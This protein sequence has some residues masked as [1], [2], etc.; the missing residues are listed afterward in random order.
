MTTTKKKTTKKK[1]RR[2]KAAAKPEAKPEPQPVVVQLKGG[3][4]LAL[5][6][7]K[8]VL[9]ARQVELDRQAARFQEARQAVTEAFRERLGA[10]LE[11]EGCALTPTQALS[12]DWE[13][14]R[15]TITEEGPSA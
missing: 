2:R 5:A 15:I 9:D 1:A 11:A 4:R 14:G 13:G 6:L 12:V 10:I 8:D 3:S 7:L